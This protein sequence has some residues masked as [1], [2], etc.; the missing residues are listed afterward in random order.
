MQ[1]GGF[2]YKKFSI[3]NTKPIYVP[4]Y[5]ERIFATLNH[6]GFVMQMFFLVWAAARKDFS[7]KPQLLVLPTNSIFI[8]IINSKF[9]FSIHHVFE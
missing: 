3:I 7:T 5:V 6:M 9:Y 1:K 8:F 2:G 4:I